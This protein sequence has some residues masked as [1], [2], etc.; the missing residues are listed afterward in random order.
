L[1]NA[2]F[3]SNA[4][5]LDLNGDG[6]GDADT[7]ISATNLGAANNGNLAEMSGSSILD[8]SKDN[9]GDGVSDLQDLCPTINGMGSED[10]CPQLGNDVL[11]NLQAAYPNSLISQ[12]PISGIPIFSISQLPAIIAIANL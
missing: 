6:V 9:D 11:C 7:T 3:D 2:P 5:Q 10:G 12:L 1:D 4:D 8:I